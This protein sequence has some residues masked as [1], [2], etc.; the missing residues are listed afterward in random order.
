VDTF[1]PEYRCSIP[2]TDEE[3]NFHIQQQQNFSNINQQQL[4]QQPSTSQ[5]AAQRKSHNLLV[6]INKQL[7]LQQPKAP[8]SAGGD[9]IGGKH[10]PT[11]YSMRSSFSTATNNEMMARALFPISSEDD[12]MSNLDRYVP[13][14]VD[15]VC[16]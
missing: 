12:V 9:I 8:H 13:G 4:D 16:P 1:F 7:S 2:F 14:K 10:I 3:E 11:T 6:G 5:Q 15:K